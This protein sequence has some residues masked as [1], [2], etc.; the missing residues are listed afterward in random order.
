[1]REYRLWHQG[2]GVLVGVSG[3]PDSTAL[4][5]VLVVLPPHVRPRVYAAHFVHG[6]RGEEGL[7]DAW[8]AEEAARRLGVPFTLGAAEPAAHGRR[9]SEDAARRRRY[10]FLVDTARAHGCV[11]VAVGHHRDDQV[12]T[13]LLRLGRGAGAAGLAGMAPSRPLVGGPTRAPLRVVRPL[14]LATR[15]DV[16]AFLPTT[17]LSW[18][19]DRS[20]ADLS[21]A[22][23]RV[24]HVARPALEA[25]LG[26]H[27]EA[28]VWRAAENLREDA[29]AL[30]ALAAAAA[31]SRTRQGRLD[32]GGDWASLPTPVRRAIVRAWWLSVTAGRVPSRALLV[33]LE[34]LRE[35]GGLDAPGG[36]VR[37]EG[38][39][40]TLESALPVRERPM[41]APDAGVTLPVPGEASIPGVGWVSAYLVDWPEDALWRACHDDPHLAVGD[42]EGWTLPLRLRP[43]RPGERLRVLGDSRRRVRNLL[44]AAGWPVRQRGA[45]LVVEDAE[46][47]PL[48]VAG[49]RQAQAFRVREGTRRALVL[50]LTAD[51]PRD[52]RAPRAR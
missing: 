23:N 2:E 13:V 27:W 48:W 12:E 45:P 5:A 8:A 25:A 31:A 19:E 30:A 6:T 50:R 39:F 16:L 44:A 7:R 21:Y 32:V 20:N 26:A 38:R 17:G 51:A 4:L 22:R 10:A 46:G 37:R 18:R 28:A 15:A 40:L 3:G 35:G 41:P 9:L 11:A 47:R 29:A 42:A 1:M 52:G 33:A 36:R 34:A 24:R 14:W 43:P 49:A